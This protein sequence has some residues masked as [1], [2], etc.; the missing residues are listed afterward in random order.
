MTYEFGKRIKVKHVIKPVEKTAVP[1]PI[2]VKTD[3]GGSNSRKIYRYR[4]IY[5][6]FD[7]KRWFEKDYNDAMSGQMGIRK[8]WEQYRENKVRKFNR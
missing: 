5:Y 8:G 6:D 7:N 4:V 3:T 2:M 1:E